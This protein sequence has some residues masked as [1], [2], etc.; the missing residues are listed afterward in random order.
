VLSIIEY[1]AYIQSILIHTHT[2]THDTL[3]YSCLFIHV[4]IEQMNVTPFLVSSLFFIDMT[5]ILLVADEEE[6]ICCHCK[7]AS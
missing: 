7:E 3:T 1:H 4:A 2:H 6:G 5:H